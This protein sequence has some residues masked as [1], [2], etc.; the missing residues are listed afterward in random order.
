[1]LDRA[2]LDCYF[3]D[4]FYQQRWSHHCAFLDLKENYALNTK[5][6]TIDLESKSVE[7]DI[8][9]V[10]NTPFP[11]NGAHGWSDIKVSLEHECRIN[12][13]ST[14]YLENIIRKNGIIN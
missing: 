10:D 13:S 2:G 4:V 6:A 14:E 1:M 9:L 11:E 12:P 5:E 7:Y 8:L 3:Y